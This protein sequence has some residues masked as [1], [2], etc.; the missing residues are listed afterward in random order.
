MPKP[1]IDYETA[2]SA[3]FCWEQPSDK[4][5]L[6][7]WVG[8]P[9]A[10]K[11]GLPAVGTAAYAEHPSTRVL[12]CS[13][14]LCDGRGIRRWRPGQPLPLDLLE[15]VQRPGARLEAHNAM[16][17][18]LIWR[19]V[20]VRLY[21][22]WPCPDEVWECSMATAHVAQ[23]P[24]ALA[25]LGD[26]LDLD[27]KKDK[28]GA[29][30][31]AKFSVPQQPIPGLVDRKTR[32]VKRADVPARWIMPEDD[33]ED[34][35]RLCAYCDQ[36]VRTEQEAADRMP[37]MEPAEWAYWQVDQEVN[38]RGLAVDRAGLRACI[39]ILGQV[40]ERY[41]EECRQLTGWN[42]TQLEKLK[43]WLS[44]YGVT[45]N[46]LDAD[47]TAELLARDDLHPS[48]RRLLELRQ[49][50][51]SASVKKTYAIENMCSND[52]RLR[53]LI[54]HHGAR[55]GRPTGEGPQPLNLPK[56]GPKLVW[57][58]CGKPHKDQPICPWCGTVG[59]PGRRASWQVDMVDHVLEIM[60][61][62]SLDMIESFFGDAMLCIQ[63]CVRPVFTA[64]PGNVLVASDY[65]SI[66]AVVAAELAGEQWRIEAFTRGDPIYLVGASK[67][68]GKPLEW[69]LDYH[70]QHGEHH[71][72]RQLIGKVSE[73][74]C[75]GPLT[76]VLTIRGYV[77]IQ[78]VLETDML[79]DG[80][81]WVEHAGVIFKGIRSVFRLDGVLITP[82]HL[83][84][85]SDSWLPA[86]T[87][88]S[89]ESTLC[90]ALEHGSANLPFLGMIRRPA[91][92]RSSFRAI[93]QAMRSV[94][95]G[96]D[97]EKGSSL[98]A[99]F[100]RP[101]GIPS[102]QNDT[103]DTRISFLTTRTGEGCSIELPPVSPGA[104][105]QARISL[106][107]PTIPVEASA[108]TNLGRSVR[109]VAALFS[110]IS[111]L[112]TAGISLRSSSTASKRTGI[113]NPEIFGS[114][115]K[116]RINALVERFKTFKPS[117]TSTSPV[118]DIAHAGPRNRFTIKT[119]RGH[120]IVHNCGY[121]GWIGSYKAF[122]ST[123]P[124]EVI[125]EQILAW[126]AASPAIV[127]AWGGQWRGPP[128]RR[129]RHELYG[130]EGMF[131]AAVQ[132]P[133]Q[134]YEWRGIT[135]CMEETDCLVV[136]LLSG[137]PLRY[138]EPRLAPSPRNSDELA[139]TYRTYNSNPKYGAVGWVFMS[140]WGGRI[141]ENIDQ[142][143]AHDIQRYGI[144]LLREHGYPLVLGVYD[145]D[146][147][148]IPADKRLTLGLPPVA[149]LDPHVQEVEYL[150]GQMPP[151]AH[152]ADGTPWPIRA[153]GGWKGR[154]YHK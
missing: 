70:A 112:S 41:G 3:G 8:P 84:N 124:D 46:S 48:A 110:H 39:D 87:L 53:N 20:C 140:T 37:P 15:Y 52:D 6:G 100:A 24:G 147:V 145:E 92:T 114:L 98:A 103:G 49:A 91:S 133:G 54:V 107:M 34:F 55:T 152:H 47:T 65:S 32:R 18:R 81:Q 44:A 61:L 43:G 1:T 128:W 31:I 28:E 7:R 132:N 108:C 109:R 19:H 127:E 13:Y 151:W 129:E 76:Q 86:S 89:D 62:G 72:D 35:E 125:R 142:A 150:M 96:A 119:D 83:V 134:R 143:V 101:N 60:A 99:R 12:T 14:D 40:L 106:V 126:R 95:R 88:G 116:K 154:R 148:E 71:S 23:Y 80:E 68:T 130:C 10:D 66:E 135:F 69:Y 141:F 36:D 144:L 22:W 26:V 73:L 138:R 58:E 59:A 149:G 123:E 21:G 67:I 82:D 5:P 56:A 4:Y 16:F 115:R 78:D 113:T 118:Y 63:G 146:V 75:M 17:E 45:T 11:P 137:R 27:T 131:I 97:Y 29:R 9:G 104:T 57:C 102:I 120:L 136:R 93:V 74:A 94:F 117:S 25:K 33:P 121:Q 77:A 105:P 51:G 122:G 139:I 90:Q 38:A 85:T 79:W 2:S 153:A 50:T 111:L 30:L 64:G 42:V